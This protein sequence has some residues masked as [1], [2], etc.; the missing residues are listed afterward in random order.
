MSHEATEEPSGVILNGTEIGFEDG[1]LLIEACER[2][3]VHIPRFCHHSRMEPVGMCRMCLVEVDTG[4]GPA[5]QPSCMITCS[6]GMSVE[7]ESPATKKAQDGVLEFLLINHPLDCPV[8]DKGGE[9][10]LQDNAYAYGPG[11][12]RFVEE[13]RHYTKPI[14]I[15][16]TVFLD[17]ERCILCDLCTRFASD[18]AGD[19]L[20]Q[21][22]GRG[23]QTEI[24]TFPDHPFASYFSGN[25]VQICPVGALTAKPYR[26][27]ARPWDLDEVE[28]TSVIDSVGSRIAVQSS[29]DVVLRYQGI[30]ADAVNWGWLS[31]KER[32]SFEAFNSDERIAEPMLRSGGE[33]TEA[34]WSTALAA[35]AD[36]LRGVDPERVG[37]IGGARLTNEAQYAW[38]KLFKGAI[39]TDNVDAQLGDGLTPDLLFGYPRA[40]IDEACTP[41]GTIILLGP[42]PREDLGALFLRL[43]HAVVN[44]GARLIELTPLTTGL[45]SL[46]AARLHPH[47]GETSL[48]ARA[49]VDGASGDV[50][51]V[52][53]GTIDAARRAI[54]GPVTIIAGRANLAEHTSLTAATVAELMR[55]DGARVLSA[56]RRGNI[57][58]AL[59]MGMSPGW[60]PGRQR[61]IGHSLGSGW[62]KVPTVAGLDSAGILAEAAAGRIDVLVLLGA[63]PL[64]DVPDAALARKGVSGADKIIAVDTFVTDSVSQADI[65]LAAA[66]PCEREG[67]FTNLEGRISVVAQKVNPRGTSRSD[68]EIAVELAAA[69]GIDLEIE[70]LDDIWA[71]L[72]SAVE[73]YDGLDLE[74]LAQHQREGIML[75][76]TPESTDV[77]T[78]VDTP[79]NDAYSLR[80]IVTRVMYDRGSIVS[81][82][83]SGATNPSS[84]AV[85]VNPYEFEQLGA[86]DGE[87]FTLT[88]TAGKMSAPLMGDVSVPRGA[89]AVVF[90]QPEL[91]VRSLIDH[92]AAVVDVR[93]ERA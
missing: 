28:S 21:F 53:R 20:I 18:V 47:P 62:P 48:V 54:E 11:E 7:T 55:L 34:T 70:S 77:F 57:H 67:T 63:D 72:S 32:F 86:V 13:K 6:A 60:L 84:P 81:R 40:T 27:K 8:C 2:N 58:G 50:A 71:E 41:G 51:G 73:L 49:L 35:A 39:G 83:P 76:P 79:R 37:V 90:A 3:G 17:R 69:L 29:H 43:R 91:D 61:L 52:S 82:C 92:T 87:R 42:D 66:G 23:A 80:L 64:A 26:F 10:P 74:K 1:E 31:D 68:W 89:V 75:R 4:R 38:T 12:S 30:D 24:N 15:S 44:D 65:V 14:A 25:T 9:C 85:R 93:I 36:A 45:S 59:D 33:L 88:S 16:E 46:A 78:P 5:L 56:V 19:A 22:Q